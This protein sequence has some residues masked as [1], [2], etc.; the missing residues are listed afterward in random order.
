[1]IEKRQKSITSKSFNKEK[2]IKAVNKS[3]D[4]YQ[5]QSLSLFLMLV[6]CG[7]MTPSNLVN[8]KVIKNKKQKDLVSSIL[9]DENS[10]ILKYRNLIRERQKNT[11]NYVMLK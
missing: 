3:E 7:G 11:S 4:L 8:Y 2:F 9:Y 6:I 1:M 5:I 10:I